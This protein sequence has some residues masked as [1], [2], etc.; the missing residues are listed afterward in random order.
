MHINPAQRRSPVGNGIV[1]VTIAC[2]AAVVLATAFVAPTGKSI[3]TWASMI[4]EAPGAEGHVVRR[5]QLRSLSATWL[6]RIRSD[7]QNIAAAYEA[8]RDELMHSLPESFASLSECQR[9][10]IFCCVV[11]HCLAPFGDSTA[12]NLEDMLDAPMLNCGNYGLLAVMLSQRLLAA[13]TDEPDCAVHLVGW[14]GGL[15]GNH[16]Q[17]FALAD[18]CPTVL[19]DPTVGLF[20]TQDFDSVA[21]GHAVPP[22]TMV[23]FSV[24]EQSQPFV[25]VV[26]ESLLTGRGRPSHLLYYFRSV[27][28][29]LN[30]YGHP[31]HWPTPGAVT[32]RQT[33][34]AAQ[35]GTASVAASD[36]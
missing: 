24:H 28:H 30:E 20:A 26:C 11:A 25:D 33:Q 4:A 21:S 19:M 14:E 1:L 10:L 35:L 5:A 9:Q 27:D 15:M 34:A 13:S 22:E 17:L 8:C 7:P 31:L 18:G 6:S 29:L 16:Q 2:L 3:L 32:W 36:P 12:Q 23:C